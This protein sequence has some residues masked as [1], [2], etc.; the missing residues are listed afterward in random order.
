MIAV[1]VIL[2]VLSVPPLQAHVVSM[3]T[4]ELR[5]SG[6]T[7]AYELRMP[8]Y[9]LQ[10]VKDPERTLFQNLHFRS[11]GV[12]G[13][14][15][16]L[17]CRD[18]KS[19]GA[20]HCSASYVWPAEVDTLEVECRFAS[21]TVSN[22]VHLLHAAKGDAVDQAVFDI[23]FPTAE[24][25]FRPPTA[26]ETMVTQTGAG[27][28]RALGGAAQ[29]LFLASLALAARNRREL[30]AL[31]GMFLGGELLAA[32]ITP[33]IDWRPNPRFV[34]AAIALTIAYLAIEILLLPNAGQRWLVAGALGAFHGLYFALFLRTSGFSPAL[35]LSGAALAEVVLLG[36]FAIAFQWLGRRLAAIQP[37]RIAATL[38]F[39]TG[40]GWFFLRLKS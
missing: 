38:L 27:M 25:R 2:A 18:D 34:E 39:V 13:R 31:A 24:M 12:E 15:T 30:L 1:S 17:A 11:N 9:E 26:F 8:S 22:H 4:G 36:L 21:V 20:Y 3:S 19:D 14:I 32:V 35:V 28:V 16:E 29:I 7:A 37:A 10:H 6:A 5:V 40:M 33:L 23:S